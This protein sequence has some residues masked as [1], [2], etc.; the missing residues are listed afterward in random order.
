MHEGKTFGQ[1]AHEAGERAG[2]WARKWSDLGESQRAEWEEIGAAVA[3]AAL[4]APKAE[5][6]ALL[7]KK[8]EGMRVDYSG[9]LGQCQR[10]LRSRGEG[11][12]AEMLRQLQG[13]LKELGQRWYAG[14]TAVVDEILQ[15]YCIER[16]ARAA[17]A[18][19]SPAPQEP[20]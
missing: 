5:A 10:A 2:R 20:K 18:P 6:P 15:L 16:E 1:I 3:R 8:H 9:L 17:I 7:A 4:A 19:T 11:A 12:H 13:H 14:D